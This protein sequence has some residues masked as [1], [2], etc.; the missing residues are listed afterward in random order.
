MY[1]RREE[2]GG[3]GGGVWQ[4]ECFVTQLM[5]LKPGGGE[6]YKWDFT[7]YRLKRAP[8]ITNTFP[9]SLGISLYRDLV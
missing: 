8:V 7:V 6:A 2:G 4:P 3:G 5:G 1:R 9:Q